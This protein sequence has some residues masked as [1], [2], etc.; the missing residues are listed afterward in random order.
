MFDFYHRRLNSEMRSK[1]GYK[2]TLLLF[3]PFLIHP[4]FAPGISHVILHNILKKDNLKFL[5]KS[6]DGKTILFQFLGFKIKNNIKP[7]NKEDGYILFYG[8]LISV[9]NYV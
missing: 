3:N 8:M 1:N 6:Y 9:G 5:L 2:K 4:S 7:L